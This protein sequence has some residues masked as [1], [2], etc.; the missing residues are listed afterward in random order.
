M[1]I[2]T[3]GGQSLNVRFGSKADISEC[4]T[5][6]RYCPESGHL[7]SSG[8]GGSQRNMQRKIDANWSRQSRQFAA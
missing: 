7:D 8:C 1:Q 4:P 5:N 3:S 2:T 6:V